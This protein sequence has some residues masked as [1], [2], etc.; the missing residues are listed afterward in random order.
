MGRWQ[1]QE[2]VTSCLFQHI[3]TLTFPMESRFSFTKSERL[4]SQ[5]AIDAL[6]EGGGGA[7]AVFPLR[8]VFKPVDVA[9]AAASVLISAPKRR[10]RHAVDRNRVKRMV[11]EAY[12][13]QKDILIQALEPKAYSLNIAF[14]YISDTVCSQAEINRSVRRA[15]VRMAEHLPE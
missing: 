4:C 5:K 11:R 2:A 12:R 14:L 15:L 1:A 13:L 10:L 8:V 6:F 7:F 3:H 9:E